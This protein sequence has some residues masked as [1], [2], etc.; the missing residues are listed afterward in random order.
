MAAVAAALAGSMVARAD[1]AR[2]AW[3]TGALV[4][5]ATHDIDPGR[6]LRSTDLGEEERPVAVIPAGAVRFTPTGRIA[7]APIFE[8]EVVLDG[9]LAPAASTGV[10]A[11]VPA[12]Q[13]G[14]AIPI[15]AGTAPPLERGQLVDVIVVLAAADGGTEVPAHVVARDAVVLHVADDA[16]TVA[17][18]EAAAPRV[19]AAIGVGAVSLALVAPDG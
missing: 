14:I 19:A 8:G 18:D 13:R 15:E 4:V 7:H 1:D 3:G 16:V 17:V 9:H 6:V 11:V 2:Q 10:A 12:G 5:V